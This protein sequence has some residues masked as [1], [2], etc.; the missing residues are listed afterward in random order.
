MALNDGNTGHDR[1]ADPAAGFV[2]TLRLIVDHP[3][4]DGFYNMALD[5]V[6]ALAAG[7]GRSGAVVRLYG[8]NPPAVSLGYNQDDADIDRAAWAAAGVDVV[9]RPTGGRAVFHKDEL[10]YCVAAPADD[11]LLGGTIAQTYRTIGE[12]LLAG[13]RELGVGADMI[14]SEAGPAGPNRAASCFAAAGRYEITADGRKIVGSAQRRIGAA[15]LQQGSVLLSQPQDAAFAGL[16]DDGRSTTAALILGRAVGFDEAAAAMI[17]GFR[18]AWKTGLE[19]SP[20]TRD[21]REAAER[22]AAERRSR[23]AG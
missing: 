11:P 10:T 3:H 7:Q 14:R 17:T 4:R 1:C 9:R 15:L 5:E 20:V 19:R 12:A 8:W 23:P 13:L 18:S 22:L 21:E 6:L 16:R 2:S